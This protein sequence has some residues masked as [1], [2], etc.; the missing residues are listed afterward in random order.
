MLQKTICLL[1]VL[2]AFAANTAFSQKNSVRLQTGFFHCFFDKSPILNVNYPSNNQ[3]DIFNGLLINSIGLSYVRSINEK[4]QIGIEIQSFSER[5]TKHTTADYIENP[6]VGWRN[7]FTIGTNYLRTRTI[8]EK[9]NFIYGT[10]LHYR[11]GDE[12]IIISRIPIGNFNGQTVYELLVE[13]IERN[14]IGINLST[15]LEYS[16]K[17]WLTF[18]SK[19]DLLSFVYINDKA[20]AKELKEVY[21]SP[22]YPSRF[23]L[24]L[25]FGIGFNF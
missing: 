4:S 24:S 16:P 6:I 18:Y 3:N 2:A 19:I 14:D 1:A 12:T 10:G 23:D 15:G 7:F 9:L 22:Q 13:H 11:T 25:K 5:Y 8:Q 20:M 21:D 17:K